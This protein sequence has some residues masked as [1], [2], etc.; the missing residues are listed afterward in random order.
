MPKNKRSFGEEFKMVMVETKPVEERWRQA[1][2]EMAFR[3][4]IDSLY[5]VVLTY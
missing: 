5:S 2:E 3:N 1:M 4:N